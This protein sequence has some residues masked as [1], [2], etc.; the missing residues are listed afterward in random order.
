MKVKIKS[1]DLHGAVRVPASKSEAHRF[2]ICAALADQRTDINIYGICSDI[3]ATA[4]CLE[5][6]GAGVNRTETGY[7]ITPIKSAVSGGLLKCRDSGSTL[8][9]LLP[10]AAALGC[11][12]TFFREGKLHE[13]PLSPLD[14]EMLKHGT[15]LSSD[16]RYLNV[17]GKMIGSSYTIAANVSSQFISGILMALP[18]LGGGNITLE[19]KIES[20]DYIKMTIDAMKVFGVDVKFE[21]N[22]L[23]VSSGSVYKSPKKLAVTGDW[24]G[25][26]FWTAA[27]ALSSE[28][29]T[30]E[31][32]DTEATQG[33]RRIADVVSS[34]GASVQIGESSIKVSEASLGGIKLDASDIP[35]IVPIISV[36]ASVADGET[37]ISGAA[38]LRIKESDRLA[39]MTEVLSL[40][41]ADVTEMSDGLAI[42][43]CGRL[44]GA[45]VDAHGDHRIAMSAAIASMKCGG[46]VT[47]LGAECV[48]KSY[49]AFWDDFVSLGGIIEIEEN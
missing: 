40:M 42:K 28:G 47:V 17:K 15:S 49:S 21:D 45:V 27:G 26:A 25:A 24:S 32:I 44:H 7:S 48:S 3:E 41:G 20:V 46:D 31:G 5:E 4:E 6:I 18:I 8:R 29:I 38:R 12:V 39:V 33:D 10:V 37:V 9:F 36:I 34:M 22:V 43:G 11:D 30:V 14:E 1:A 16:G 13:R 19:G 2:L 35:D 23:S